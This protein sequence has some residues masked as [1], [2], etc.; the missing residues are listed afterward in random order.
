MSLFSP[1]E[2]K[3]L[4]RCRGE[5]CVSI[6]LPAHS[7]GEQTREGPIRL[8]NA[9]R[10]AERQLLDRRLRRDEVERILEPPGE[11]LENRLF[12]QHQSDGLALFIGDEA[13]EGFRRYRAPLSFKER[14]VVGR[15]FL[16]KPLMPLLRGDGRFYL[17]ALSKKRVRLFEASR[18]SIRELDLEDIPTSLKDVVGYDWEQGSM[19]FHTR[20]PGRGGARDAVFHG[21]GSSGEEQRELEKFLF[22]VDSGLRGVVTDHQTPMVIA[23]VERQIAAF[24]EVSRYPGLV[25]GGVRGNPDDASPQE[26]QRQAWSLVQPRFDEDRRRAAVRYGEQAGAGLASD[27][28]D[29]ILP[30]SCNGR[31]ETLFAA[32]HERL[33]GRYDRDA[34]R[35]EPGEGERAED[36]LDLAAVETLIHSGKVFVVEREEMPVDTSLA[37]IF[38]YPRAGLPT[39]SAV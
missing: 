24:H 17:L 28:L 34:E 38:R 23:A 31:V 25:P 30:A 20:A 16:L 11:L 33:H 39:V 29:V 8:K 4:A 36:L 13:A 10:Q 14:V 27:Q 35:T 26:L 3:R 9:L 18:H 19:Q 32:R 37:A 22:A 6:Y 21:H 1:G 2:L 7:A 15:R 12:W 5:H